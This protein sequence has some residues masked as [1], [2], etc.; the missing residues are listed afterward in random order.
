MDACH[1]LLGRPWQLDRKAIHNGFK[2]TYSFEI[3]GV[4]ITLAPLGMIHVPKPSL[5]EGIN[6]LTRSE[7]GRALIE[8]GEG[9]S[10]MVREEKDPMDIPPISV[11][12]LE[13]FGDVIPN[14]IPFSLPPM[15]D[16]QHCTNLVPSSIFPN[17]PTYRMNPKDH[18]EL[19][20]Q[21]EEL[22]AKG[23][24]REYESLYCSSP[25]CSQKGWLMA[26]VY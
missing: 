7:V 8:C 22:I 18:E 3:D 10:I 26:Y 6:L 9:F 17:K 19:Q 23:L 24:V 16:M 12:F 14:E 2:N 21:V 25:P 15:R 1:L 20:Q 11:P 4:K 13:E 5:R